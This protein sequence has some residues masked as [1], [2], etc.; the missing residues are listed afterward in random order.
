MLIIVDNVYICKRNNIVKFAR[1]YYSVFLV[2]VNIFILLVIIVLY[3][4]FFPVRLLCITVLY[5]L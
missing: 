1:I 4:I 3:I 2:Y 5:L